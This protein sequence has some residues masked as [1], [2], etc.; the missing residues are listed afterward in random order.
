MAH[1]EKFTIG[2]QKAYDNGYEYH[3]EKYTI[4]GEVVY[5]CEK[6]SAWARSDEFLALRYHEGTWAAYDSITEGSNTLRCRQP[7]FRC[8]EDITAPGWHNWSTNY[9][10]S[11]TADGSDIRWAGKLW[12]ETRSTS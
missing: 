6:G 5:M 1:P 10:A 8:N 2:T 4:G 3:Y 7:V 11:E 9:N 12:A